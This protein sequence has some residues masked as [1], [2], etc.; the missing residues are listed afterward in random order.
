MK[1]KLIYKLQHSKLVHSS[2][3]IKFNFA[4]HY[5]L[6]NIN[7]ECEHNSSLHETRYL[8]NYAM[9]WSEEHDLMLCRE[10]LA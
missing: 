4:M 3:K 5:S 6:I 8:R 2:H 10:V 1:Q 9:K 7:I